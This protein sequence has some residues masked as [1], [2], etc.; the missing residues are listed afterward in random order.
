MKASLR[1]VEDHG[2]HYQALMFVCPGCQDEDGQGGLHMLPVNS[3]DKQPSW[4]WD[5]NLEEPTISP[6][7]LT[8]GGRLGSEGVCHSFLRAGV[9]EFLGDCT[10]ALAG[11]SVPLPDLYDWAATQ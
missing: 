5:G 1:S 2:V 3:A 9:F 8:R 10:H 7:I 11:Q 4:S 6:S